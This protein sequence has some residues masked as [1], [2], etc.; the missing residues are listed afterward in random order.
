MLHMEWNA[1]AKDWRNHPASLVLKQEIET[2]LNSLQEKAG[3]RIG[4][5]FPTSWS[6]PWPV[7]SSVIIANACR[8]VLFEQTCSELNMHLQMTA[9]CACEEWV[10]ALTEKLHPAL[11]S[12]WDISAGRMGMLSRQLDHNYYSRNLLKISAGFLV[13]SVELHRFYC[14]QNRNWYT[15][16]T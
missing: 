3:E 16:Q 7:V 10:S 2:Q 5:W 8:I 12:S 4:P 9:L 11:L 13:L 1:T 6:W 15:N 14:H